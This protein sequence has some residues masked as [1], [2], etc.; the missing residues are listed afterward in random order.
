MFESNTEFFDALEELGRE[1]KLSKDVI[2]EAFELG[3]A[4]AYKKETDQ[5]KK[6]VAVYNES[7]GVVV[8]KFVQKVV[9]EPNEEGDEI[10]LEEAR[11]IKPDAELGEV[12]TTELEPV[13]FSRVAA[14][15]AKQVFLQRI[16]DAARKKIEEEMSNKTGEIVNAIVRRIDNGVV[17]VEIVNTQME[18]IMSVRDQVP[19]EKYA[20]GSGVKVYVKKL[21]ETLRGET[22]VIVSRSCAGFVRKLF[23]IEVPEFRVGYVK[24]KNIVRE[25]GNRTKIAV[26]SEDP[27]IDP[28]G[29]CLGTRNERVGSVIRQLD[30]EKVDVIL[31]S[32]NLEEYIRECLNPLRKIISVKIDEEEKRA[33]VVVAEADLP[34]AIGRAGGNV[35]LASK[36]TG[37]KIEFKT[38]EELTRLDEE[39]GDD[40]DSPD[41]SEGLRID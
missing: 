26:Y 35:K 31:Y 3:L 8:F 11:E 29:A 17:Y 12:I 18:G 24:V 6:V 4:A 10:S 19:G 34:R 2:V 39:C 38:Y 20:I 23:E 41:E 32:S 37:Y 7:T 21:R 36:L 1:K 25:A 14:Q 13:E 5:N 15:T 22:Q 16:N 27:N 30:G 9:E 28:V 33:E 40:Q